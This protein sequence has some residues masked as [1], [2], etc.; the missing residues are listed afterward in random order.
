[1]ARKAAEPLEAP[2][3]GPPITASPGAERQ[4]RRRA[5]ERTIARLEAFLAAINGMKTE[6]RT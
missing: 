2:A 5:I 4:E 6:R 1:M 3:P